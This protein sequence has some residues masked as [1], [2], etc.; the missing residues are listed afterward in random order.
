MGS[1]KHTPLLHAGIA[2]SRLLGPPRRPT[3]AQDSTA[4]RPERHQA[5]RGRPA[6][7]AL[8]CGPAARP[9]L[10]KSRS[11]INCPHPWLR[12]HVAGEGGGGRSLGSVGS[13]PSVHEQQHQQ[14]QRDELGRFNGLAPAYPSGCGRP[15]AAPPWPR[16]CSNLGQRPQRPPTAAPQGRSVLVGTPP[17]TPARSNA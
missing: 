12:F 10:L 3:R 5:A 4:A 14:H 1:R 2:P 9:R 6:F 8:P 15:A 17:W 16:P 7:L 13:V 11:L